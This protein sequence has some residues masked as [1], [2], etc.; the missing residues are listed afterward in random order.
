MLE[1]ALKVDL[2]ASAS[3]DCG[4]AHWR[5]RAR[6]PAVGVRLLAIGWALVLGGSLATGPAGAQA[7]AG[8]QSPPGQA[9]GLLQA[10]DY[11]GAHYPAVKAALEEKTSA[12]RTVDVARTA[13]LPQVNLL[14]QINR[15]TVNNVTGVLLPQ[16]VIPNISGPVLAE[17][18][19]SDWNSAAGVLASWRA[20]DFGERGA[21]VRAARQS[22]VAARQAYELTRLDVGAATV[23]AY[24]N[25]L[26]ADALTRAAQANVDRLHTFG[27]AVHV[28][29][30][31]KLRAEV[32]A[33]EADAAEALAQTRLIAAR[34]NGQVQRATLSKLLGRPAD[35]LALAAPELPAHA[36]DRVGELGARLEDHPAALQDAARVR[37]Q[38]AQLAAVDRAYAPQLDVLAGAYARGAGR[39]ASGAF[40]EGGSGLTPTTDNWAVGLQ[41]TFPLG[42][43]PTVR[44]QHGAQRAA[45][46][47]AR[48]RYDQTLRDLDERQQQ[49]RASLASAEDIARITPTELAA[50]RKAEEQQRARFR[51]GLA[52]A[53][54]VTVA[55]A[56]LAQAESQDAIARLNVWRALADYA[57]ASGDLAPLR[58]M[59]AGR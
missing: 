2:V 15:A 45:V 44:A 54:D 28:L 4:A 32:E 6:G 37:E 50:A 43:L 35:Q 36:L 38:Q 20:F 25:V 51:S 11:A 9:F 52:T 30:R 59:L 26:A 31:N 5:L 29:V 17:T 58:A 18:G 49:A 47:A 56:A 19:R 12:D 16:S 48:D 57:A 8:A 55:E 34:A 1:R 46:D 41:V 23:D 3:E 13:Y 39:T 21:R 40:N 24:V 22:A 33:E 10:L 27:T 14:W 7:S 53:V 42:S